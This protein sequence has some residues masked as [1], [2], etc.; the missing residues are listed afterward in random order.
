MLVLIG[1]YQSESH[2]YIG[3]DLNSEDCFEKGLKA[4]LIVLNAYRKMIILLGH[5]LE[6]GDQFIDV[7]KVHKN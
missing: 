3:L 4:V 1:R 6:V 5:G 2:N 7:I